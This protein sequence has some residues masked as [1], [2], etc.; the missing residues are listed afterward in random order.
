[1]QKALL[2]RDFSKQL[3]HLDE[4]VLSNSFLSYK[5]LFN[6]KRWWEGHHAAISNRARARFKGNK[7]FGGKPSCPTSL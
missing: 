1:M 4:T 5:V 2:R 6:S 3:S 7:T